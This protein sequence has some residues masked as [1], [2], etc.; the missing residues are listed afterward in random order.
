MHEE[1]VNAPCIEG[2]GAASD[3]PVV[4]VGACIVRRCEEGRIPSASEQASR[5]VR[6]T[7]RPRQWHW[8]LTGDRTI[9][10]VKVRFGL[11]RMTRRESHSASHAVTQASWTVYAAESLDATALPGGWAVGANRR[12]VLSRYGHA[13]MV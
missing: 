13:H 8:R 2:S 4:G 10:G 12:A 6:L 1:V 7:T 11:N 3:G 9:A 5:R